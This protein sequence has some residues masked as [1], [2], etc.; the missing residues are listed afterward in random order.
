MNDIGTGGIG[1]YPGNLGVEVR[2]TMNSDDKSTEEKLRIIAKTLSPWIFSRNEKSLPAVIG[3]ILESKGKTLAC[4]ESCTGGLLAS[5]IVD[6]S[7]ASGWF[8]GSAVTYSNEA[9]AQILG[10]SRDDIAC[11]GA[12]SPQ[13]AAQM[14]EGAAK[15]Y[16]ADYAMSTTGIAGPSGGTPE[17]PV[18]TVF[19]ALRTPDRILVRKNRFTRGREDHRW[20]TSQAVLV[21]LWLELEGKYNSHPWQDGSEAV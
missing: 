15:I 3:K 18:G 16:G 6:V 19:Y 9:K 1:F 2:L 4:A 8:M 13:V 5:R 7:G 11:Y 17:K 20:R 10:V 21:M 14:A 12:V